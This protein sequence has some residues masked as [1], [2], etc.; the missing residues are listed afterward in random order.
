LAMAF[1]KSFTLPMN[2]KT[3]FF[4]ETERLVC[5]AWDIGR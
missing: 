1:F 2:K 5:D 4:L 3:R